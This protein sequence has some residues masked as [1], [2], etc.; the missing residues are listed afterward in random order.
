MKHVEQWDFLEVT[1]EGPGEGNPFLEVEFGARFRFGHRTIDV[2]GFYDG[3]GVYKT[4]FM[5]DAQ[6]EWSY[7]TRSNREEL[8]GREGTFVCIAPAEGNRGPVHVERKFHFAYGDGAPYFQFGTTCYAWA[9][10]GDELE[11]LTLKTLAKAPKQDADVRFSQA[12]LLQQKRA[13]V[14]SIRQR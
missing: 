5:P 12:L 2:D 11:E 4:R 1:L 13:G 8:D 3:D 7:V 6:G 9:H 10:Q 14:L